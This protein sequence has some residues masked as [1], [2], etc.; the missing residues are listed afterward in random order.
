MAKIDVLKAIE[1]LQALGVELTDEQK[2]AVA[3]AKK[4]AYV[5]KARVIFGRKVS[6]PK[7]ENETDKA[8]ANR[9]GKAADSWTSDMLS[10]A[11]RMTR[12]I[13]G[14]TSNVGRGQAFKRMFRIETPSGS[15][16]VELSTEAE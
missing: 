4:K 16:K 12:E 14:E 11:E 2:Q 8:H 10:L 7:N 6:L 15:L 9:T 1:S 13:H 3:D 5:E